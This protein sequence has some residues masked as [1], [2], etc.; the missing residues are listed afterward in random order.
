MR[1]RASA[2]AVVMAGIAILAPGCREAPEGW[3]PVLEMTSTRFL[4][5]E[6]GSALDHLEEARTELEASSREVPAGLEEAEEVLTRLRHV[7]LPAYRARAL[8]YDAYRR[9]LRGE[10]GAAAEDLGE[11][12][13]LLL[14]VGEGA[15]PAL[16]GELEE[17]ES[18]TA[19]ARLEVE[20]GS[21][22]STDAL[23]TLAE[24]LE[25]FVVKRDLWD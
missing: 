10:G 4:E 17:L 19:R 12:E 5:E 25:R 15:G 3:T 23:R 21:E 6:T 14:A 9:H 16:L 11:I 7:Y 18:L 2:T 1:A 22:A 8:A 20:A 13:E 24:A